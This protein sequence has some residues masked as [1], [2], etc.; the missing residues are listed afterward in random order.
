MS[1]DAKIIL[2]RIRENLHGV[3]RE[4]VMSIAD[5]LKREGKQLGLREGLRKGK[6]EG[7]LEKALEIARAM[8]KKSMPVTTIAEITQLSPRDIKKLNDTKP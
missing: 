6:Q 4:K 7:K 1:I 2:K 8:L 5:I 3:V